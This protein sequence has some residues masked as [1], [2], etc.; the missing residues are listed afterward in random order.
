MGDDFDDF[1]VEMEHG[2]EDEHDDHVN[3]KSKK[4]AAE[5]FDE[6]GEFVMI[7]DTEYVVTVCDIGESDGDNP[8]GDIG[9][10]EFDGVLW[11]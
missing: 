5:E 7:F 6:F 3:E 8:R 2:N 10:L 4:T 11:I 1:V 9:D